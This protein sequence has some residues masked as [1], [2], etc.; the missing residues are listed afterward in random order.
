[1]KIGYPC[2]NNS[3]K[4]SANQTF[5]LINYSENNLIQKIKENLICLEKI[6]NFNVENKFLFFRI[7]S[8]IVPFASHEICGFDWLKH[9]DKEFKKIG[10]YIKKSDI[11]ISMHPDQFVVLNSKNKE[12]VKKSIKEINYHCQVLDAMNLNQDAKVQIHIGGVYNDKQKSIQRFIKNYI[13]LKPNIKKRL[14]VENDHISYSLKDCLIVNK[15]V[16]IPIVFDVFH[17]ECLNNNETVI[18]A[19][20]KAAKTWSEKDGK[21]MVDYS[22]QKNEKRKGVHA[23]TIDV[24]LFRFF[25][26][27][28]KKIDCDI[29]LEIK[30]KEKSALKVIKEI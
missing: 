17:H 21:L 24:K 2:I 1:M 23:D 12:I 29:M 30:D 14:V 5:R 22:S 6:L 19:M 27:Q 20:K 7:G 3:L 16:K 25:L 8:G 11:R 15:E 28:I 18:Q 9:F 13:K 26:N 10:N 4:C